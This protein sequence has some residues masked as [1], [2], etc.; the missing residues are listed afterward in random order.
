MALEKFIMISISLQSKR[1]TINYDIYKYDKA[2]ELGIFLKIEKKNK[3]HFLKYEQ[4]FGNFD[5][6][7]A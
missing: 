7:L 4:Y 5:I 2:V 6:K 1:L 3:T